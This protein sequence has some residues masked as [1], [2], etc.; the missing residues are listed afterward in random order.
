MNAI[1]AYKYHQVIDEICDLGWANLSR[2]ELVM[3]GLGILL[4]FRAISRKPDDRVRA[5]PAG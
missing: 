1:S 3:A 5:L 2:D 4:L